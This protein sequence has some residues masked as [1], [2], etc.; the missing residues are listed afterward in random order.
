[1]DYKSKY[2][3]YKTKYLSL[4][5]IQK[6]GV[7]SEEE[8]KKSL[9]NCTNFIPDLSYIDKNFDNTKPRP[10]FR[11]GIQNRSR[12][13]SKM[14]HLKI[15]K[16]DC[17]NIVDS[18]LITFDTNEGFIKIIIRLTFCGGY[19][20]C[21]PFEF[22]LDKDNNRI[23]HNDSVFPAETVYPDI[24]LDHLNLI[25][26]SIFN[27]IEIDT[28]KYRLYNIYSGGFKWKWNLNLRKK[29][30]NMIVDYFRTNYIEDELTDGVSRKVGVSRNVLEQIKPVK[31]KLYTYDEDEN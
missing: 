2:L 27:Y 6:G 15:H 8:Y 20:N 16:T 4:R 22:S 23:Y 7:L 24:F 19:L 25:L 14:Y 28:P 31:P 12:D 3:K 10:L 26:N 30:V 9:S 5:K 29:F 21:P 13:Y 18:I 11:D 17:N 1:M